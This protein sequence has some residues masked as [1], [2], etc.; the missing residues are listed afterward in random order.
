MLLP[1]VALVPVANA[2]VPDEIGSQLLCQRESLPPLEI[3]PPGSPQ[4]LR[5]E[6]G[7]EISWEDA[8]VSGA[9]L[10]HLYRFDLEGARLGSDCGSADC[11]PLVLDTNMHVDPESPGPDRGWAYLV[12]GTVAGEE[13]S[14]G[15]TSLGRLRPVPLACP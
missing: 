7:V 2:L 9:E 4:P 10:F 11:S 5:V 6:R 15:R 13:G 1:E 14:L 8:A 12:A 3:S